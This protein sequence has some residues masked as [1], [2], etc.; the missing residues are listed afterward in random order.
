ML[1]FDRKI[2]NILINNAFFEF[3]L[4]VVPSNNLKR[5]NRSKSDTMGLTQVLSEQPLNAKNFFPFKLSLR[6]DKVGRQHVHLKSDFYWNSYFLYLNFES[7]SSGCTVRV[8]GPSGL[9]HIMPRFFSKF[10]SI[11]KNFYFF[12][13]VPTCAK[14]G[15]THFIRRKTV[16]RAFGWTREKIFHRKNTAKILR[17]LAIVHCRFGNTIDRRYIKTDINLKIRILFL[18]QK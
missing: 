1:H 16:I 14:R 3:E 2:P 5:H 17:T 9:K 12:V 11:A 6:F 10:D 13:T 7:K 15:S 8:P 18:N 4:I